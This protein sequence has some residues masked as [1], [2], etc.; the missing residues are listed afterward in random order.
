MSA[1]SWAQIAAVFGLL[2]LST[3]VLGGTWPGCTATTQHP[4]TGCFFRWSGR[5]TGCCASTRTPEQRWLAYVC[6][7]VALT[8]VGVLLNYLLFR[9]PEPTHGLSQ[10][11]HSALTSEWSA[12][13]CS[14]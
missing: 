10:V 5:C 8:V 2:V 9:V 4:A 7:A 11:I 13:L 6:S 3:P 1:A 12:P 14:K